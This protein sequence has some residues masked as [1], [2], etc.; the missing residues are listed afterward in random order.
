MLDPEVNPAYNFY[1]FF[2]NTPDD[3]IENLFLSLTFMPIEKVKEIM[4]DHKV[5]ANEI[6][7]DGEIKDTRYAHK[8]L[9]KIVTDMVHG[10]KAI[11]AIEVTNAFFDPGL[12]NIQNWSLERIETHFAS[13]SKLL[14]NRSDFQSVSELISKAVKKS[15][16]E[17]RRLIKMGGVAINSDKVT[18]DRDIKSS[19]FLYSKYILLKLVKKNY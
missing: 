5:K 13:V 10:Q 19:D 3:T 17:V 16:S 15:K 8:L 1:Q 11:K 6:S 2:I 14:I 7:S 12:S 9:A 18:N 4:N